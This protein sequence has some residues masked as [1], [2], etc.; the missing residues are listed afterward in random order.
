M[1][2]FF[3]TPSYKKIVRDEIANLCE[4]GNGFNFEICY[5]LPVSERK[6]QLLLLNNRLKEKHENNNSEVDDGFTFNENTP[7]NKIKNFNKGFKKNPDEFT[8][9]PKKK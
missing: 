7:V 3:L 9:R 4:F 2:C 1:R 6:L 8:Y 5:N